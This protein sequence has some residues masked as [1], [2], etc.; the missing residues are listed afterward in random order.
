LKPDNYYQL[1]EEAYALGCRRIQFIGGEPS[2]VPELPSYIRFARKCGFDFVEV[3]T[4][5][6]VLTDGLFTCLV[7]NNVAVATSFYSVNAQIHD[8]VTARKGSYQATLLNMQK[9]IAHELRLRAGLIVMPQNEATEI[10]TIAFLRNLGV[11][12]IGIDRIR[13]FGRG[14]KHKKPNMQELCGS[15]WKGSLCVSP[16]GIASPCIMSKSWSVGSVKGYGLSGVVHSSDLAD[17]RRT[18][19]EQVYLKNAGCT[20]DCDPN[21][22]PSCNPDSQCNPDDNC[23]PCSPSACNPD[24]ECGPNCNPYCSPSDSANCNPCYPHGKCNP[25]LYDCSPYPQ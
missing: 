11:G 24:Y 20:P 4:N 25:D 9:V 14:N 1:M 12:S 13:A 15:C 16:T 21:C 10:E 8:T 6:Y 5:L 22:N 17:I 23:K 7:D 19:Y 3:F 2:I 18:I